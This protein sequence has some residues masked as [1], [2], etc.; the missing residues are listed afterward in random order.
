MLGLHVDDI[1]MSAL[2]DYQHHLQNVEQSFE[3]GGPWQYK[4]FTFVGR[5]IVQNEDHSISVDQ[6]AYVA[7]V[8]LTKTKKE[9]DTKLE[10]HPELVTEFRSGI[11]SLQWLAGTTRGDIAADT[12]LL[13]KPPKDLTVKDLDEV[14]SVL[15]YVRATN[16]AYFKVVPVNLDD[17]VFVCYGDSG[18]ANAPN[19]KSQGGLVVVTTD[20]SVLE[21]AR[22][23]SLL[24]WKSFR[25][26]RVLR[27]TLAAEA[28]S[29]DRA[30][31]YGNFAAAMF[32]EMTQAGHIATM[33]ERPAYEVIPVTDARSLWDA[34]HRLST[35]FQEKR[36]E[37][38]VAALRQQCRNLRWVPTEQQ[39]ADALTKRDRALRDRFREWMSSPTV[40]LVE[41]KSALDVVGAEQ[42]NSRW[43]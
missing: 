21:G 11:G 36:V 3:W 32:S 5:H 25:H 20:K 39:H 30:E 34:V 38:D 24:E 18:W 23:A 40:T 29:L 35:N 37:I 1:I 28:A 41:S 7:E 33:C 27:S 9:P 2:S 16:S 22:P 15:R 19:S 12:S 4:D 42:A 13:Q 8:P 26:Q 14:N 10:D 31:D 17:L 6:A 43:R